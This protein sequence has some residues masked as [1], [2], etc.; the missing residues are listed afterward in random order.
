M[1]KLQV[2]VD[3]DWTVAPTQNVLIVGP[4][5]GTTSEMWRGARAFLE[6]EFAVVAWD[7][8]GH[9]SSPSSSTPLSIESLAADVIAAADRLGVERFDYAGVSIGGAVGLVLARNYPDRIRSVVEV[10]EPPVS[11]TWQ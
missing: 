11:R 9:G 3:N 7:L 1:V 6:P 4:S 8:P 2:D 5:L 10:A